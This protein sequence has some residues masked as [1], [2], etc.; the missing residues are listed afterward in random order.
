MKK[1][2]GPQIRLPDT[3]KPG[4]F[5]VGTVES[6]AAARALLKTRP[7]PPDI[8]MVAVN[9]RAPCLNPGPIK[10]GTVPG[11]AEIFERGPDE[12]EKD[13]IDRLARRAPKLRGPFASL[14]KITIHA[15]TLKPEP[16]A[17]SS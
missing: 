10:W 15:E 3:V 11:V 4:D 14:S 6:R 9:S 17:M 7:Q 13:F 16:P 1:L 2:P 8:C 5:P 12:S